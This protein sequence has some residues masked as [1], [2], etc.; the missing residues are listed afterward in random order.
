MVIDLA[1]HTEL[2]DRCPQIE[3]S[4]WMNRRRKTF[5]L[6]KSARSW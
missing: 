2:H 4:G 5:V 1:K 3:V 6:Q